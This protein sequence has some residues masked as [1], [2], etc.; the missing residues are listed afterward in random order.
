[1]SKTVTETYG[2]DWG[3]DREILAECEHPG[4]MLYKLLQKYNQTMAQVADESGISRPLISAIRNEHRRVTPATAR[5]LGLYF[6]HP[7]T[8]WTS[9]QARYDIHLLNQAERKKRNA[10]KNFKPANGSPST[11][12]ESA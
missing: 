9:A 5:R 12:D 8:W 3:T 7:P 11:M 10:G 2:G 4:A 1:M 6:G